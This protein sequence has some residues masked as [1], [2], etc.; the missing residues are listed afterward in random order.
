M[1]NSKN[2]ILDDSYEHN[3]KT[4]QPLVGSNLVGQGENRAT[5]FN[6]WTQGVNCNTVHYT[7]NLPPRSTSQSKE[8]VILSEDEDAEATALLSKRGSGAGLI[9]EYGGMDGT[10]ENMAPTKPSAQRGRSATKR[11]NMI[12]QTKH[13]PRKDSI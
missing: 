10:K 3:L 13:P 6:N 4:G 5:A 7:A 1:K 9:K 12:H 8:L 11:Q 2:N